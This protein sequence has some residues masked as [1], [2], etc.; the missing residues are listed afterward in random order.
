MVLR[1]EWVSHELSDYGIL[2]DNVFWRGCFYFMPRVLTQNLIPGMVVAEDVYTYNNQLVLLKDTELTD[3]SITKLEFYSILSVR[4][5]EESATGTPLEEIPRE[6]MTYSQRIKSSPE[7]KEF[8][9]NFEGAVEDFKQYPRVAR[10]IPMVCLRIRTKYYRRPLRDYR[11]S[12][13]S[14]ICA[15]T[16]TRPSHTA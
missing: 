11:Y 10:S 6:E 12:T 13:C 14:T 15:C 2:K 9:Q 16:M 7:Y 3:K 5:K 8:K 1:T 4:V